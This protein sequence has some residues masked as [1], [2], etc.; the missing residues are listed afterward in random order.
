MCFADRAMVASGPG[1][2]VVG[3]TTKVARAQARENVGATRKKVEPTG[4]AVER[5]E[6][7]RALGARTTG[8]MEPRGIEPLTSCLQSRCVDAG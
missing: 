8:A 2:Y 3:R 6:T 4:I 7:F 5:S 1:H